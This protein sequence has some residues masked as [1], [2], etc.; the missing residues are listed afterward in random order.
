VSEAQM[1]MDSNNGGLGKLFAAGRTLWLAGLGA[2]AGVEEGTRDLFGRL[3]ERGQPVEDR[4]KKTVEAV[5]DR[6]NRTAQGLSQL[7]QDTVEY[8]SRE[9]LKRFNVM[10]RED[11]KLLS[12]RLETLSKKL[13]EYAARK[14]ALVAPAPLIITPD[15]LAAAAVMEASKPKAARPRQRKTPTTTKTTTKKSTR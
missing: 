14:E 2:V 13:D 4:Q 15:S 5:V 1:N 9:M 10:T 11:V 8:E 7:V 6:A 12:A 3:V